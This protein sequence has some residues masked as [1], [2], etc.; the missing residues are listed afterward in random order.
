MTIGGGGT[1]PSPQR[2]EGDSAPRDERGEGVRCWSPDIEPP[3]PVSFA[4]SPLPAG[5][6][7][8]VGRQAGV[9]IARESGRS[10]GDPLPPLPS[11]ERATRRR[12]ASGVRGDGAGR[13]ASSPLT[14]SASLTRLSPPGRGGVGRQAGVAIARESGRSSGDPLPPLPSGERA[15]RR[16]A[17]S[18]VR[19]CG[20]SRPASSPLTRSASLTRLSPPGRG[21]VGRQA[22][23]AIARESGRSSGD[24]LPPLPSGE[25]ATRRN[26]ASGV[27]GMVPVARPRAPSPG[28]LR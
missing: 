5:E 9:A 19:G 27:R 26:A 28:Q 10:S 1:P 4:D 3:H 7:G 23:V 8:G 2:G 21:G 12:A 25:R 22:G 20:A 18:G 13:P 14:R 15:T 17:A 6:R 11:G 24:P 16:N